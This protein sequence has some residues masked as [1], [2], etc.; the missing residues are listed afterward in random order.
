VRERERP[1]FSPLER[2]RLN[3]GRG[4]EKER[5]NEREREERISEREIHT[6]F[7]C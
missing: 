3:S 4:K 6:S 7:H 1:E 5:E 2:G